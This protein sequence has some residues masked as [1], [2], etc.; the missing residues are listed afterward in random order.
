MAT[1]ITD[2]IPD[3]TSGTTFQ[4]RAYA[5]TVNGTALSLTGAIITLKL[6]NKTFSNTT[7][8][9]EVTDA[10]NGK[11]QIKQQVISVNPKTYKSGIVIEFADGTIKEYIKVIWS[12]W[13]MVASEATVERILFSWQ[14]PAAAV[15]VT[16]RNLYICGIRVCS[17]V[18]TILVAATAG[19][20]AFAVEMGYGASGVNPNVAEA[21]TFANPTTKIYRKVF[22]GHQAWTTITGQKA[23][24]ML[25]VISSKNESHNRR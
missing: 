3:H 21:T 22:L 12:I 8:E 18:R 23:P 7:G 11:F 14:N 6:G 5:I 9:F 10:D 20:P 17:A 4:G 19:N 25:T 13:A 16:G 1:Y 24:V 15:N 2:T